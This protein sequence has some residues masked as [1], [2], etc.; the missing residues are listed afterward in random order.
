MVVTGETQAIPAIEIDKIANADE[1][2][3]LIGMLNNPE[4]SP[5]WDDF[6]TPDLRAL[7]GRRSC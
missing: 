7:V 4:P 6:S 1:R 5:L 3:F 2:K